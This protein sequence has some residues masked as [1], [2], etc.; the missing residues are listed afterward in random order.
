[1][2]IAAA[3]LIVSIAIVSC[4]QNK[5]PH[6]AVPSAQSA[7]KSQVIPQKIPFVMPSDSLVTP[8]K[9]RAWLSCNGN[10]DSLSVRYIDSFKV[11]DQAQRLVLQ[12]HFADEQDKVCIR[13]GL[14][15]GYEE[16]L[17]ILKS[18]SYPKNKS[19][20]DT[21]SIGGN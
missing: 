10:L 4:T 14:R 20:F 9:L 12:K 15:S 2:R 18:R 13:S 3:T 1:M 16:Y 21:L 17:W 19:R 8:E 11:A 7:H 5:S 6:L